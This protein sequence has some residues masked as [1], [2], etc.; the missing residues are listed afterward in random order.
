MDVSDLQKLHGY[1]A[2]NKIKNDPAFKNYL[3][4]GMEVSN[5]EAISK[6]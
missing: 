6:A 4:K 1:D 5:K 3:I 2:I